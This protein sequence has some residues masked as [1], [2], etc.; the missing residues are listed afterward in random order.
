MHIDVTFFHVIFKNVHVD[1]NGVFYYNF[2]TI[3]RLK[4]FQMVENIVFCNYESYGLK[5]IYII[6][7]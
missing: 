1:L 2:F 5:Y 6:K 4:I 7:N 3:H